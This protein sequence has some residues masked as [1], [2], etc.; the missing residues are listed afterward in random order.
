MNIS[1]DTRKAASLQD[2]FMMYVALYKRP[3]TQVPGQHRAR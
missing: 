1:K 3:P 2:G